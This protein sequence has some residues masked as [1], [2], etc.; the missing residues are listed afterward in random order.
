MSGWGIGG[1]STAGK[2][3]THS[4]RHTQAPSC[5]CPV[6]L[7]GVCETG[8]PIQKHLALLCFPGNPGTIEPVSKPIFDVEYSHHYL[9]Q[10]V[11]GLVRT[12]LNG[13]RDSLLSGATG[14]ACS[15]LITP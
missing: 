9:S 4:K 3:T 13:S 8:K 12:D 7:D 11:A 2:F 6:S 1:G 14:L 5:S 10:T 15:S